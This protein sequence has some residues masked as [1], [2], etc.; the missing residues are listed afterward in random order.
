[1]NRRSTRPLAAFGSAAVSLSLV[2]ACTGSAKKTVAVIVPTS[3][4]VTSTSVAPSTSAKPKPTHQPRPPAINPLTGGKP[5]AGPVI[6]VKID[7]TGPGRPQLNIQQADIVYIE[8]A[9]AGLTRLLAVFDSSKPTVGYVRSVRPSDP[10]LLL[11]Y[12]KITLAASGG[13]GNPLQILARSGVHGWL[14]DAGASFYHRDY[15]RSSDYINV[16]LDLAAVSRVVKTPA[17]RSI[18]FTW[19]DS[20]AG[21]RRRPGGRTVSTTVGSTPV[22]FDYDSKLKKYVRYIDGVRQQAVGGAVVATPNVIVQHCRVEAHPADTDVNHNPSQFTHTVGHG[23][24]T[25][26]RNG[27]R[28]SGTW[29]RRSTG[30]PTIL[31]DG[32]GAAIPL[33]PGGAWVILVRTNTAVSVH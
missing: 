12:G 30:S 18:G 13:A 4:P 27:H 19:A 21:L 5:V 33:A 23:R 28:V 3:A 9:E 8:E 2:T 20:P 17:A 1:M 15:S 25:V 29:S 24:V 7:D 11:Q 10:E 16:Q 31:R 26:L 32:K 6:A 14:M 22:R